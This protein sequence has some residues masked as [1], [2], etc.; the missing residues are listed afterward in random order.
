MVAYIRVQR[1]DKCFLGQIN[2][3]L[4]I[5]MGLSAVLH[6]VQ[7]SN[8][9]GNTTLGHVKK[10]SC[11]ETNRVLCLSSGS[12]LTSQKTRSRWMRVVAARIAQRR[13]ND[14]SGRV[15]QNVLC[16]PA[17]YGLLNSLQLLI[18]DGLRID[19]SASKMWKHDTHQW[20]DPV[21]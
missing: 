1:Q 14:A 2:Q 20:V 15:R 6:H 11:T 18:I 16:A 19:S 9:C 5:L 21:F 12:Q 17:L 10:K 13:W 4:N 8:L 7:Q 3:V